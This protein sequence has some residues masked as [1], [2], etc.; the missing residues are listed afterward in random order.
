MSLDRLRW[1]VERIRLEHIFD[2]KQQT[3]E[4]VTIELWAEDRPGL[5]ITR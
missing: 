1:A 4:E 3:G 5:Q 2:R